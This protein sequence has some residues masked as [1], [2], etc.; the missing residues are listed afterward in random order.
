M[1][2][3]VT[4]RGLLSCQSSVGCEAG[5]QWCYKVMMKLW[6]KRGSEAAAVERWRRRCCTRCWLDC[7]STW[8]CTDYPPV[9]TQSDSPELFPDPGIPTHT[10]T[11]VQRCFTS[12]T[13]GGAYLCFFSLLPDTSLYCDTTDTRL[14]HR[15]HWLRLIVAYLWRMARLSWRMWWLPYRN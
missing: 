11:V 6:F 13:T 4:S 10:S 2:V 8:S 14:V 7:A 5:L 9:R 12:Y 3:R 1:Q 15:G